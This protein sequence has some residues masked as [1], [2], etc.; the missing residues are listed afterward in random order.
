MNN[1]K[2]YEHINLALPEYFKIHDV[3][4]FVRGD[5]KAHEWYVRS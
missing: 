5:D 2:I 4:V 1:W 3:G